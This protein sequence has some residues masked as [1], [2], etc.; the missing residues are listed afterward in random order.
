MKL[1]FL[2]ILLIFSTNSF[3]QS[4]K[5]LQILLK[6]REEE[7]LK[8]KESIQEKDNA[9]IAFEN[10]LNQANA[11]ISELS[12][13][14]KELQQQNKAK[15]GEISSL[16]SKLDSYINGPKNKLAEANEL[17][18][19]RNLE[20]SRNIYKDLM[21]KYPTSDE[22]NE[23]SKMITKIDAEL[24]RLKT[25]KQKK[26]AESNISISKDDFK[27]RTFYEDI[28]G[29]KYHYD[30]ENILDPDL[31]LNLYFSVPFNSVKAESLRLTI[32]YEDNDWLFIKKAT[33]LIDGK[34]Y[35]VYGD[36]ER[37]SG[38]GNVY[39]WIDKE[40][41]GNIL[42]LIKAIMSGNVVKVRFTGG[43]YYSDVSV[44]QE[45]KAALKNIY[46]LYKQKGGI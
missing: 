10:K 22:S 40:V 21:A 26:D 2:T 41:T 20:S 13:S 34:Q 8:I 31:K 18:N 45:Q 4:K 19:K 5:E 42:V 46:N 35:E 38:G 25:E 37:D 30:L 33:F 28:R 27:Q 36:F 14:Q 23:A 17:F 6:S 16:K 29:N 1:V 43:Q 3:A 11:R 44:N 24:D 32:G 15:D 9:I 7:I 39:E 12:E